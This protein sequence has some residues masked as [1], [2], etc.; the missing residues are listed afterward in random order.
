MYPASATIFPTGG[1]WVEHGMDYKLYRDHGYTFAIR[2]IVPSIP[3][4][5]I[6]LGE[7][8]A[9]HR[10]DVDVLF[11][12][13]TSGTTWRGGYDAG[14]VDAVTARRELQRLGAPHSVACYHAIDEQV[15]DTSIATA[16][17]WLTGIRDGM[18]PYRAG[19]YAQFSVVRA[20]H[21][22]LPDV[23]RWQT[24][25][26]SDNQ[27]DSSVDILQLNQT[28]LGGIEFDIDL[29]Y[30]GR[31]G[32]WYNNPAYQPGS[33][34]TDMTIFNEAVA[35]DKITVPFPAG[36]YSSIMLGCDVGLFGNQPQKI[37][38]A[39]HSA[40][41]GYDVQ[42]IEV[43]TNVPVEVNFT[44]RDVNQVSFARDVGDG[45]GIIGIAI[46]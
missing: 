33:E 7:I 6:G 39:M 38:V 16:M 45:E 23:F 34:E 31:C 3:G 1:D 20:A 44:E 2:Y 30:T 18:K 43:G 26:W 32:E 9:A 41:K 10:N 19:I 4:K 17:K 46:S 29:A 22:A 15:W 13:E 25:A 37:R 40:A 5:L 14:Y 8:E 42:V 27:V 36:V 12:Y 35:M 24:Q 11:V 21:H 28:M